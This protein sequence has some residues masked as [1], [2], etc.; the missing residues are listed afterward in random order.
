MAGERADRGQG[1]RRVVALALLA[2]LAVAWA[3]PS[4][5]VKL[6]V[7]QEHV[8]LGRY[9]EARLT[10]LV[11][12][13]LLAV[14]VSAWLL[15]GV[16]V[17]EILARV[18]LV[19]A[20]G[21]LGF[22]LASILSYVPATPRY[23][24]TPLA[25]LA[26]DAPDGVG[27]LT[28]RRHPNEHIE[29]VRVDNAGPARSYPQAPPGFP[30]AR[31]TLTTDEVGLR[32]PSRPEHCETV[33]VGDSFAE[34]SMVDD[35]EVWPAL[36]GL[37]TGRCVYNAAVSG[38]SPDVYLAN[39]VAFGLPLRPR[40]V[41]V[42][43]YEGNDFKPRS[44]WQPGAPTESTGDRIRRWRHLAFK[45]SPLRWRIKAWLLQTAGP[46]GAEAP[47]PREGVLRWMPIRIQGPAGEVF[48]A[49]EPKRLLRL[50]VL[51]PERF[52]ES[53][54]FTDNAEIFRQLARIVRD[55]GAE[56]LFL[57]APSKVHVALP[58]VR[59][60]V[61][62]RDLYDFARYEEEDLPD[63]ET[64]GALVDRNLDTAERTFLDFCR[65]E[66]LRCLSLTAAL[67]EHLA[68]GEPVY[69]TYDPHWTRVG[70]RVVA[71]EIEA[72]LE[73]RAATAVAGAGA[74]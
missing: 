61:S 15:L 31:I 45:G 2:G 26:P 17:L 47:L 21:A 51:E 48:L 50:G 57:Y 6:V 19:T 66:G 40:R 32:N 24:E 60:R 23:L 34:G 43:V 35:D 46:I 72:A 52:P 71:E 63:P 9:S 54:D 4:D 3:I 12:A 29:M 70:H 64:F 5:V 27:G 28:R 69:F 7:L 30:T 55:R 65:R 53:R 36:L 37:H 44:T 42:M 11:L 49:F 62:D 10:G 38:A 1:A 59:D 14:P 67:R 56:V 20:S 41:L 13:S 39:L 73:G 25:E 68:R 18:A 58:L 33:V 74:P 8:L 16:G 22:A